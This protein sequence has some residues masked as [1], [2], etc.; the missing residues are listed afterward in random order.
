MFVA[1]VLGQGYGTIPNGF[2]CMLAAIPVYS[3]SV[4]VFAARLQVN[5]ECNPGWWQQWLSIA[6]CV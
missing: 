6:A 4:D 5:F 3:V 1:M 2:V